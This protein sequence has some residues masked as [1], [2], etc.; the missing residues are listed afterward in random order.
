MS[1]TANIKEGSSFDETVAS[2]AKEFHWNEK[3]IASIKALGC[4][5]LEEFRFY[6]SDE[7]KVSAWAETQNRGDATQHALQCARLKRVWHAVRKQAD[8]RE[9]DKGALSTNDLDEPGFRPFE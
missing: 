1:S 3:L 5:N 9:A 7:S 6:W 4:L 8:L 2:I